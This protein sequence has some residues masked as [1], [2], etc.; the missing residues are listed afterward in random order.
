MAKRAC[1]AESLVAAYA[2]YSSRPMRKTSSSI[3]AP[4]R[5]RTIAALAASVLG[6]SACYVIPIDPH[7]GQPYPSTVREVALPST[8]SSVA[9]V[10]A[11]PTLL[12]V[13]LYPLNAQANKGG[14]LTAQVV[15]NNAGHGTFTVPYLGDTLQG[16]STRVDASYA[17]FG[18]IHQQVLGPSPRNFAG[19]RGVANA[20]GARGV[21]AQCEYVLTGPG[22]GT[23]VCQFSDGANFQMHFGG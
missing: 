10:A 3:P 12:T 11:V 20:F 1:I 21:N 7:T 18:R 17:A 14:L 4:R 22:S 2:V 16:E 23:G 13:R 8:T 15:D 5:A 6:V 19:R 9:P